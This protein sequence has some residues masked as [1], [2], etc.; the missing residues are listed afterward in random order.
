MWSQLPPS[1][2]NRGTDICR[3]HFLLFFHGFI[4]QVASINVILLF[5]LLKK[6]PYKSFIPLQAYSFPLHPFLFHTTS[7]LNNSAFDQ[8]N[9]LQSECWQLCILDMAQHVP[10]SS[11]FL[12][13]DGW[14]WRFD[15]TQVW[16]FWQDDEWYIRNY[17]KASCLS[18]WL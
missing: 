5:C 1:E 6:S 8:W 17:I 3:H 14:I 7:L 2:T 15:E 12:Q 4:T 13:T 18:L 10:L 9:F 11:S 16:F